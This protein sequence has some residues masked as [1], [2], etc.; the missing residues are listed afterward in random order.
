MAIPKRDID[1]LRALAGRVAEIAALPVQREKAE[2]WRRLNRLDPVRPMVNWHVE[3]F[4]WPEVLP[5]SVLEASSEI[6]RHYERH[7][8]RILYQWENIPDDKVVE[9]TIPYHVVVHETGW[10]IAFQIRPSPLAHGGAYAF[11]PVLLEHSDIE[12]IRPPEVSVDEPATAR[13]REVCAGIFDGIL[14]PVPDQVSS[15]GFP[16]VT[17]IDYYAMLRGLG[18]MYADLIERPRWVHEALEHMLQAVLSSLRQYQALGLLRL[19]NGANEIGTSALGFTDE[20]PQPDFDGV[21]VR[22]KDL[23][24][25]SATQTFARVSPA[26]HEEFAVS[27][28][29]RYLSEFGLSVYGCCEPLEH[30]MD[31]VR[32]IPNA[33]VISMSEWVDRE[34]A[35]E[36]LKKDF[37]FAYKPTGSYLAAE[38]WDVEA[39]RRDLADLLEKTRGCV[40]EIHHN[41][42]STCRGEP[43]RIQEW[44]RMA[45]DLVEQ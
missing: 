45:M 34:K 37:V 30:K 4:C 25:F 1:L 26:M 41:S 12:R 35:A 15:W 9:A 16:G 39:A 33:R 42:C 22:T 44:A 10:G 24:G 14:E 36:E 40:V 43:H 2:M 38:T 29:R 28:D 18:Q 20:L 23:W 13:N 21:H 7:L 3:D 31:S 8:R 6:G 11:E 19:N 32:T 17:L 5:D 27:Y